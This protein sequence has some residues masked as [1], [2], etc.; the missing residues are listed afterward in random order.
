MKSKKT[1][2]KWMNSLLWTLGSS[3]PAICYVLIAQLTYAL[4]ESYSMSAFS[5]GMIFLCSRV[6]DGITDFIAGAI[7]HILNLEKGVFGI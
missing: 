5:V 3:S 2:G 6:F 7:V 1:H 4:T